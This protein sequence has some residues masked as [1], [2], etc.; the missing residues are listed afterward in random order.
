MTDSTGSNNIEAL[1]RARGWSMAALA[2]KLHTSTSTVNRLEKGE[3]A[4]DVGWLEK[5]ENIFAADWYEI[6]GRSRP[7]AVIGFSEDAAPFQAEQGHPLE[8]ASFGPNI[9]IW[10][11]RS[12]ALD[13]IGL[14]PGDQMLVDISAATVEGIATGDAVVI[15]LTD[16]RNPLKAT[17]L[18]RQYIEP[19]LFVTNSRSHNEPNIVR[20]QH[21]VRVMG[22]ITK[23]FA[24]IGKP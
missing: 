8:H 10:D 13:A 14:H 2:E 23:R 1:R 15:Q 21:D 12:P 6:A 9:D 16:P 19:D 7:D 18:L 4:L 11:V 20:G 5:L 17:T 24:A 3:V 22:K